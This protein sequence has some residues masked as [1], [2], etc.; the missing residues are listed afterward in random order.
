MG[1][2]G[3]GRPKIQKRARYKLE[4]PASAVFLRKTP[5]QKAIFG[6][7]TPYLRFYRLYNF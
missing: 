5:K 1:W 4:C 6:K 2:A 7:M 3:Q